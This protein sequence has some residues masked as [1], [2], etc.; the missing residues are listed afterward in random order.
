MSS[1]ALKCI[2]QIFFLL[3]RR[4]LPK[5]LISIAKSLFDNDF[6]SLCFDAPKESNFTYGGVQNREAINRRLGMYVIS[7]LQA[8]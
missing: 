4:Y 1:S 5:V 3:A 6:P 7:G 2:W 8:S